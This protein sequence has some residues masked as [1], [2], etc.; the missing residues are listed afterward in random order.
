MTTSPPHH[1]C[2]GRGG[3]CQLVICDLFSATSFLRLVSISL[4]SL[5]MFIR[6][7]LVVVVASALKPR[8]LSQLLFWN[9]T[10]TRHVHQRPIS[11]SVAAVQ[12]TGFCSSVVQPLVAAGSSCGNIVV[13]GVTTTAIVVITDIQPRY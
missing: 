13:G 7:V 6:A 1:R 3:T 8:L 10:V 5:A 2:F 9:L 12:T 4:A 11:K